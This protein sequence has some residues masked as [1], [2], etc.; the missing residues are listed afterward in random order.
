[1]KLAETFNN[2]T[3]E[4]DYIMY[5]LINFIRGVII[6]TSKCNGCFSSFY[7]FIYNPAITLSVFP[8]QFLI[9]FLLPLSL[10]RYFSPTRPLPS[11]E[12]SPCPTEARP[13][14]PLLHMCKGT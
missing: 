4:E 12:P 7:Y 13:S 1:L 14:I 2:L 6:Y 3:I 10:R 9:P 8:P 5:T 11:L